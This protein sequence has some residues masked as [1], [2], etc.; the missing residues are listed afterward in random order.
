M[1][2]NPLLRIGPFS[3]ASSISVKALRAYHEMGLLVPA[4]IDPQT[5]YR[6]YSVAQ[7][8]DAAII[9]RLRQL[10]VPLETVRVV[11]DAHDPDVTRKVLAE[12]EAVLHERLQSVQRAIDD[13]A[14]ALDAPAL[15]TPV[16]I[17]AEPA[18][19]V[20]MLDATTSEETWLDVLAH[21]IGTLRD[22]ATASGA[23]TDG[24]SGACYPTLL[25]DDAQELHAFVP[26]ANAPMLSAAVRATGVRVDTLPAA[27]VAVLVHAGSYDGLEDAYRALGAWVAANTEPPTAPGTPNPPGSAELTVRECYVVGPGATDDE[28]QF[29]TEL[30]WP[31]TTS[32]GR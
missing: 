6:S 29:L 10:D 8:T 2:D 27:D 20:L 23:V 25:E 19:T 31:V 7:L 17:R 24:P 22:A 30:C 5:G 9:R 15:A 26:V 18:R 11:L 16:H 3:R 28:T 32:G 13:L 1:P 12:H 14:V 4:A 21:A